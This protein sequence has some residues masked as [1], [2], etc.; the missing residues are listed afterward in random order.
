LLSLRR[1]A[2]TKPHSLGE[3]DLKI[4]LTVL[5]CIVLAV[6]GALAFI[7]SGIYDVSASEPDNAIVAWALH[8]I[9]DRS[10]DARLAGIIVPPGLDE[11]QVIE[12]GAHLFVQNC[13]VCH[14]GPGLKPTDIALGLNP[15]PPNLF[16]AGR[17]AWTEEMFRFIKHGVKMTAM[18]GFG[19]THTDEQVWALT[20]FLRKAPGMSPADFA[21]QTGIAAPTPADAKPAGG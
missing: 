17:T 1:R 6:A 5:A 4:L 15:K 2:D 12:A 3:S 16:R 11:P 18:P 7:Y 19:R 14:G 9:S 8:N 10:V 13:I 20:A 21:A